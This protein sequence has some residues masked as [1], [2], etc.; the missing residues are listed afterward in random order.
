MSSNNFSSINTKEIEKF[1]AMAEEWWNPEGNLKTLHDINLIRMHYI[2]IQMLKFFPQNTLIFNNLNVLDVGCGGGLLC[3]PIC[4]LGGKVTGIDASKKNI[5]VA[6]LHA[7]QHGLNITYIN[8]TAEDIAKNNKKFDVIFCLEI[9][10]HI[11]N[12]EHFIAS[13]CKLLKQGGLMFISTINRT[14][15]SY[16]L[17]ILG[18]EY[19]LRWVPIGTH[20]WQKFR[21]PSELSVELKK[22][23][24][25][26]QDITGITYNPTAAEKWQ[27]SKDIEA[28][29]IMVITESTPI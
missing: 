8:A 1:S 15:K 25:N 13:C 27:M 12:Y 2:R 7:E 9:V 19:I 11:E 26:I 23:G 10:E 20:S 18:A 4:R 17:A 3:E 22:A 16:L 21:K 6:K 29:Y 14:I 24:L 28:N 5:E